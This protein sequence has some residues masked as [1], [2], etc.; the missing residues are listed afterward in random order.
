M[1]ELFIN[2]LPRMFDLEDLAC[3]RPE[4]ANDHVKF[5]A[6]KLKFEHLFPGKYLT[7]TRRR[8]QRLHQ[9]D[10]LQHPSANIVKKAFR[11]V[12]LL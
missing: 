8:L 6:F 3:S 1:A 11:D 7:R 10:I 4:I 2:T 9:D 5:S 12:F